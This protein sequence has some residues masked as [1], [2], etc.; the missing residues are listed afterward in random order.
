M[1][2]S[3]RKFDRAGTA[4]TTGTSKA[5]KGFVLVEVIVAMVLLAVAVTSL[6]AMMYSV[7]QS[8]QKATGNAY[9]NG[10]LMQEVNRLEG[11]PYDSVTVG[12]SS[13]SVSTGVYAHTRT[14]TVSEPVANVVKSVKIVITPVNSLY[15]PDTVSFT[16]TKARSSRV[17][18]TS[19]Q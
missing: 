11:I 7:S 17:L 8:G 9:R 2:N 14:I 3:L 19:C 12:T 4:A 1:T 5:R 18:C 15:K 16:R 13:A 6:A 10:V